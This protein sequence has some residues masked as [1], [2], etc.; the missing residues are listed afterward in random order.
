MYVLFLPALSCA[1]EADSNAH[2]L[3]STSCAAAAAVREGRL[4][5]GTG[6]GEG[7]FR[8]R[9]VLSATDC[10]TFWIMTNCYD[11]ELSARCIYPPVFYCISLFIIGLLL[12]YTVHVCENEA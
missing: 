12:L 4:G 5:G 10:R 1:H 2:S 8:Q 6:G 9:M 7:S 3:S 11:D